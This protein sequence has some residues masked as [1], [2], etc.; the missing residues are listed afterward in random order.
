MMASMAS[1]TSKARTEDAIKLSQGQ[2]SP[3]NEND[4]NCFFLPLL[5]S[6]ILAASMAS[7]ISEAGSVFLNNL[8]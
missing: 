8:I 2:L 6:E 7:M 4:L 5:R 3:L 1:M